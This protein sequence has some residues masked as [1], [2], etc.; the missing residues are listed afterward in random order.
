MG[1]KI[2]YNYGAFETGGLTD[3]G[4]PARAYMFMNKPQDLHTILQ[5]LYPGYIILIQSGAMYELRNESVDLWN[6]IFKGVSSELKVFTTGE[7]DLKTQRAGTSRA[8]FNKTK[9]YNFA[10][11]YIV[12]DQDQIR[13]NSLSPDGAMARVIVQKRTKGVKLEKSSFPA[14][15]EIMTSHEKGRFNCGFENDVFEI[16]RLN[17]EYSG[18]F[19]EEH[20]VWAKSQ[21]TGTMTLNEED[22]TEE[23][24]E[25]KYEDLDTNAAKDYQNLKSHI[26]GYQADHDLE[27][28]DYKNLNSHISEFLTQHAPELE[29]KPKAQQTKKEYPSEQEQKQL[30]DEWMD[31][32]PNLNPHLEDKFMATHKM[33]KIIA[34]MDQDDVGAMLKELALTV[35]KQK[36]R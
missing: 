34:K 24:Q 10:D 8:G 7:G 27:S 14:V 32:R 3:K 29:L 23:V 5:D 9:I 1:K 16:D 21:D 11:N 33:V 4:T 13:T 26:E 35:E 17:P 25:E 28:G 6:D 12:I 22:N 19:T 15:L 2:Q 36:N 30:F 20:M 31:K 18:L